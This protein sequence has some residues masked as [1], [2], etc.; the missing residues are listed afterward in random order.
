MVGDNNNCCF[1]SFALAEGCSNST[2]VRARARVTRSQPEEAQPTRK[3]DGIESEARRHLHAYIRDFCRPME[4]APTVRN[5]KHK[6]EYSCSR[7]AL[8]TRWKTYVEHRVSLRQKVWGSFSLFSKV[9]REHTEILQHRVT[10]HDSCDR[11]AELD[12]EEADIN[13]H[14]E[15][16]RTQ[17]KAVQEKRRAHKEV[18]TASYDYFDDAVH[19]SESRPERLTTINVDSPTR[20]EMDLPRRN[21]RATDG[22]KSLV[23][24]LKWSSKM[25][26]CISYGFGMMAF[27]AHESLGSGANLMLTCV[28]LTLLAHA[29]SGRP[30][31]ELLQTQMDNTT[32]E[33]KCQAML[34]YLAYMVQSDTFVRAR[35]H[36]NDKGHTH[37][38]LDQTFRTMLQR[39]ASTAIN[40]VGE[41]RHC[42]LNALAVYNCHDCVELHA[43]LDIS[44]E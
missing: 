27:L 4:N 21:R 16:G 13:H 14:T 40:T 2:A 37:T 26:G 1:P 15:A 39:F 41:L 31:G 28:H 12:K 44:G 42:I 43:L 6:H 19:C 10:G 22:C 33:M 34:G 18:Y 8:R 32:S 9:F 5:K 11:C 30:L 23:G 20:N 24:L 17:L 3:K 38:G 25:T 7:E 36:F 35:G 29:D